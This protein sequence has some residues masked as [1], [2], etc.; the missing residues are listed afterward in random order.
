MTFVEPDTARRISQMVQ[1]LRMSRILGPLTCWSWCTRR[2]PSIHGRCVAWLG[3]RSNVSWRMTEQKT[4][5]VPT[6]LPLN[7]KPWVILLLQLV[8]KSH[9]PLLLAHPRGL[10]V[11]GHK[12][13]RIQAVHH[14]NDLP[15]SW[16]RIPSKLYVFLFNVTRNL[17]LNLR[18]EK[19][20][21]SWIVYFKTQSHHC[22]WI[23][24]ELLWIHRSF[25]GETP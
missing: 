8:T 14:Q 23:P 13:C 17:I 19:R 2:A 9:H 10:T 7:L 21:F 12:V 5:R 1:L 15:R 25:C 16:R 4:V 18:W 22:L 6:L 3:K 24:G 20:E 11:D